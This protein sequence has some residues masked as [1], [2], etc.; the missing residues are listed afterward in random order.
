MPGADF[1]YLVVAL[2]LISAFMVGEV[3][4]AVLGSSLALFADAGHMLTDVAALAMSAWAVRLATRPAQGRWTYGLK[5]AEILSAATNGV[6]LVAIAVLIAV[7]AFQRLIAPKHVLGGLVLAV[8]LVGGV[9]NVFAAWAM[10]KANRRSLNVR[11]AY[12][13][14]LTDL[15]AFMGT[16]VAGLLILLTGWDRADPMASL[17]VVAL[18]ARTAWGLL[19]DAG[20]VLLQAAPDDLDLS[21]VRATWSRYHTCLMFTTS[22]P[23]R[24]RPAPGPW[25][26]ML[27]WRTTASP[28]ATH[29]KSSML[30]R[31]AWQNISP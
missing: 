31:R 3:V 16:A 17:L 12:Q 28:P 23:G 21:D 11:G 18:M 8:A 20:K 22:M 5:R 9:I 4:G 1:H 24:L 14:I 15:Y 6:S 25:L 19:R 10:A 30:S 27:W 7:E 29:R 2:A 26:P 13:H